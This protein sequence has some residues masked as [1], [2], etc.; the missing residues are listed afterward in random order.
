[1]NEIHIDALDIK[2]IKLLVEI[3][4]TGSVTA[5]AEIRGITQ[6][7]ASYGLDRLRQAFSDPLF[8]RTGRG[9]SPTERG[10]AI[11]RESQDILRRLNQVA[12]QSDFIPEKAT[13]TFSIC[14]TRYEI[15][16]IITPLIRTLRQIAPNVRLEIHALD[17]GR[18]TETL[19]LDS[20]LALMSTPEDSPY[21]KRVKLLGDE[22]VTFFD[23][24]VRSSPKDI[25][26]FCEAPHAIA[27]LGGSKTTNVDDALKKLHRKREVTLYVNSFETLPPLMRGSDLITT[28]P[29]GFHRELMRDFSYTKCPLEL[30]SLS[31]YAVW[32]V[33][34]DKDAGHRWLRH[35]IRKVA[36]GNVQA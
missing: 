1:M 17:L 27:L 22:Q 21:L 14:A 5:A 7:A 32:H 6:S 4:Q 2:T 31:V 16:T 20:D 24:E 15:E 25:A 35:T 19:E 10:S 12:E 28:I 34:K 18:L 9:V 3:K 30:P 26:S 36:K 29:K 8:V 13:R 23:S 11:V 33:I